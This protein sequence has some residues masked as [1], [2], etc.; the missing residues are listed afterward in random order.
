MLKIR[1]P[2]GR[3]IFNMGIA[4]PGKTVFLI[5]TAPCI[6]FLYWEMTE[7]VHIFLCFFKITLAPKGLNILI[8]RGS[9]YQ[10]EIWIPTWISYYMYIHY[11]V[12]DEI[13]IRKLQRCSHW[14]LGVD[15]QFHPKLYWA[16]DYLS[17]LGLKLI[18]VCKRGPSSIS[19]EFL[20]HS[21]V[22]TLLI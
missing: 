1:R 19:A 8:T 13:I 5:E 11:K 17:M 12:W 22:A 4:I 6:I 18:S 16:W 10:Y 21:W 3:L 20:T 14:S 15:K 9:F 7:N 2:L